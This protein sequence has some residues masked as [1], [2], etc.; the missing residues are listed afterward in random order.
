M[1]DGALVARFE[2][3]FRPSQVAAFYNIPVTEAERRLNTDHEHTVAPMTAAIRAT[4][5]KTADTSRA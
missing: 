1:T 2:K 3:M 5:H 4:L